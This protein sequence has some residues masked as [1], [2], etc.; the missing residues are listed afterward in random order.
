M[1]DSTDQVPAEPS[2]HRGD[3]QQMIDRLWD[4]SDPAGS[5]ERFREA[6]DDDEH[7]AHVRAVMTTQLARALGIQGR[8]DE[9]TAVLD[10]LAAEPPA[11]AAPE[12][13]AAEIRARVA[14]ER[15]RIVASGGRPADAVPELTR[16]VREAALAGSPFLVLDALHML[17]LHDAGHEEE[18]AAEGFDVLAGV[19]DP[20]VLRW[21]VALHNNLG[22]TMHDSG[23]AAAAL[24]HFEQAVEVADA[25]GTAEQRHVARWSVA[26]CLR[27]LGRTD[28]ALEVQRALAAA[29]PDDP[30]VQAELAAL[31][32]AAPTI[33]A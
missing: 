5:E 18:W 2:R 17:A 4:F 29:R 23:R 15:G 14:I 25:Y 3:E 11:T 1:D 9:A 8:A 7:P 30:Y 10:A 32:G 12:R 19:R 22:W 28:E 21:G 20:R 16:G 13:D 33:E 24:T 27:S 31:T 6:A 26:R